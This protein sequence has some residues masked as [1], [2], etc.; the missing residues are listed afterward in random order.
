MSPARRH[1]TRTTPVRARDDAERAAEHLRSSGKPTRKSAPDDFNLFTLNAKLLA[2][3]RT[4]WSC[5]K[6]N[7]SDPLI[8]FVVSTIPSTIQECT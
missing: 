1:N 2:A 7:C 3:H 4:Q 6:F 8:S 5:G